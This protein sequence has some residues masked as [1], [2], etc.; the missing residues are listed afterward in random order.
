V[1]L[2]FVGLAGAGLGFL[3]FNLPPAAL[4]L[5][6]AGALLLGF[7]LSTLSIRGTTGV[8]DA[9]FLSVPLLAMGFPVLD[10]VLSAA[11][12]LL[13]RRDPF[14]GDMDHIHHRFE[15]LNI[16]P[17]ASL[18]LLYALAASFAAAALATHYVHAL[19]LEISI[20]AAV[21]GV[22]ALVLAKLGYVMTMWNSQRV[23]SLR[24]K[25]HT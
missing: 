16:G 12:R 22:V 23:A 4:F 9:V 14:G 20:F 1:A 10:T 13:D 5:G 11:R 21:I 7:L 24:R 17:R 19:L 6:D 25:M 3:P 8:D 15:A 2:L 18:A